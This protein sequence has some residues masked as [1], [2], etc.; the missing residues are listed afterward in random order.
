MREHVAPKK[1]GILD[2]LPPE[3]TMRAVKQVAGKEQQ[4]GHDRACW[5]IAVAEEFEA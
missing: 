4:I 2:R 5:I 3:R 1:R